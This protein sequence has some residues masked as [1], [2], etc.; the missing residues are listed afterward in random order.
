MTEEVSTPEGASL[1]DALGAIYDQMGG[2]VTHENDPH[3][4][5]VSQEPVGDVEH[6]EV[7][8]EVPD[9]PDEPT[10]LAAPAHWSAERKELFSQVSPEVQ[11]SWLDRESEYERGIQQKAQEAAQYRQAIEPVKQYLELRGLDET[12]WIR[13]MAAYT[14]ALE[15]DPLSV[16]KQVAQQY[17]VDL[18]QLN[19][20]QE[21]DEFVDP[22]VKELRDQIQTLERRI[23]ESQQTAQQQQATAQTQAIQAFRDEKD[24]SGNPTHPHFDAVI[25][26][27]MVLAHGYRAANKAPPPLKDL[28]ERAVR[29]RPD[30]NQPTAQVADLEKAQRARRARS[31]AARA[32]STV[33]SGDQPKPTSLKDELRAQW[34]QMEKGA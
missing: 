23:A 19:Q 27:I 22:Q 16:I 28:Y 20:G 18:G 2:G 24:A 26:D 6:E 29:M 12:A 32:T 7:E 10:G 25:E 5:V 11:K 13:Q 21:T 31:A 8:A 1:R 33:A 30:L 14:T 34:D 9:T 3:R 17:G 15:S 4:E